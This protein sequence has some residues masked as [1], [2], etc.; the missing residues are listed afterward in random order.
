MKRRCMIQILLLQDEGLS[1][2]VVGLVPEVFG[3][4]GQ[5]ID[6]PIVGMARRE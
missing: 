5:R 4:K 1:Y 3:G 6:R 2:L